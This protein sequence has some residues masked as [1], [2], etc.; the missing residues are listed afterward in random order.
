MRT[1]SI[2]LSSKNSKVYPDHSKVIKLFDD[3]TH[4]SNYRNNTEPQPEPKKMFK[5]STT[6]GLH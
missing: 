4:T 6:T 5:Y 2:G 3:Q 1:H